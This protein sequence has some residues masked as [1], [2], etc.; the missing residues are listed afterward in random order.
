MSWSFPA[1]SC[2]RSYEH[3][4]S[5][6]SC[7]AERAHYEGRNL[8]SGYNAMRNGQP[9]RAC[10]ETRSVCEAVHGIKSGGNAPLWLRA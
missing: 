2:A 4:L 9:L 7:S 3:G 1:A 5:D 6:R 8:A 10:L